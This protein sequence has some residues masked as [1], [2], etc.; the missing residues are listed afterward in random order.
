MSPC[1]SCSNA[2]F[3]LSCLS[4]FLNQSTGLCVGQSQCADGYYADIGTLKCQTCASPCLK[5]SVLSTLCTA[6]SSPLLLSSSNCTSS[7]LTGFYANQTTS[8]C[9]QCLAPCLTCNS[10]IY[11]LSCI[12]GYLY[13]NST[14]QCLSYCNTGEYIDLSTSR[15]L[16]CGTNCLSCKLPNNC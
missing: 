6:C 1:R 7:C 12:S 5:C 14:G 3:C 15:C 16:S 10:S 9:S 4:N 8:K 2:T 13:S 11:C